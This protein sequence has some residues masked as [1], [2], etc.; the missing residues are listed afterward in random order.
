MDQPLASSAMQPEIPSVHTPDPASEAMNRL[1]AIEDAFGDIHSTLS[2]LLLNNLPAPAS[3]TPA[4]V[5][6]PDFSALL[7]W[8]V[9]S[10]YFQNLNNLNNPNIDQINYLIN[11]TRIPF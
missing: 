10:F 6:D 7:S 4:P 5:P 11:W 8:T 3:A 9:F 2:Q 1:A